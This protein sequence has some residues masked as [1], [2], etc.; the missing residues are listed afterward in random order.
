M[1]QREFLM[2]ILILI[3]GGIGGGRG[4]TEK[5][6][7]RGN[8]KNVFLLSAEKALYYYFYMFTIFSINAPK[9]LNN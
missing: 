4:Q 8:Q 9:I 2:G 1:S 7:H 3:S 5:K 6:I